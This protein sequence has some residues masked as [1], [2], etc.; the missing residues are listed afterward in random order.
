MRWLSV[1]PE[2]IAKTLDVFMKNPEAPNYY[3]YEIQQPCKN[4]DIIWVEL[5]IKYTY[6]A[7]G[8]IETVGVSRNIEKRKKSEQQVLY[9]SYHDQLTGLYN[10]RFY[11]EEL[12]RLDTKG[13][14]P[15][16]M[17]WGM[18]FLRR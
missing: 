10:R 16:D 15:L 13:N 14:L 3:I 4:G 5:S 12:K 9:L 6:N 17:S 7:D 1:R 2:A 18:N 8:D 11:E